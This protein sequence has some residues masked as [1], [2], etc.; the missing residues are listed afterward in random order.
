MWFD[1]DDGVIYIDRFRVKKIYVYG[2]MPFARCMCVDFIFFIFHERV[3]YM[4][5][6][7]DF[8]FRQTFARP[9]T[10]SFIM[11]IIITNNLRFLKMLFTLL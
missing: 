7:Y 6:L 1:G 11:N 3:D 2:R 10:R 5:F 4:W 9:L 8:Q